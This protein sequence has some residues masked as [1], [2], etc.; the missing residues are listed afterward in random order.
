M[1]AKADTAI[2]V[3]KSATELAIASPTL[4]AAMTVKKNWEAAIAL[5]REVLKEADTDIGVSGGVSSVLTAL[6]AFQGATNIL[7]E[8]E[9]SFEAVKEAR[10][11]AEAA[12]TT[13]STS[14]STSTTGS[15]ISSVPPGTATGA[16]AVTVEAHRAAAQRKVKTVL[17]DSL[18][19]IVE[20]RVAA[21]EEE[22]EEEE[23]S[24]AAL[25]ALGGND[26]SLL[27]P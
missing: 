26:V 23:E 7:A 21:E 8:A 12:D 14:T 3:A 25:I 16:C 27:L 5:Q 10:R 17:V 24:V 6:D 19:D 22:E 20:K 18:T 13:N 4:A 11:A 1:K 2:A 15:S 9:A